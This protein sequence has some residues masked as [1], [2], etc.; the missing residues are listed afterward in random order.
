M[1]PT[2]TTMPTPPTIG[3]PP[4]PTPFSATPR[5][6][7]ATFSPCAA[8]VANTPRPFALYAPMLLPHTGT[9]LPSSPSSTTHLSNPR[10]DHQP[11]NLPA[12]R[13]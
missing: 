7:M 13:T 4:P 10:F 9:P 11:S 5:P 2:T 1:V 3:A 12:H 6:Y 8:T